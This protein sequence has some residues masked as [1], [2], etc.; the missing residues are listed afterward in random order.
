MRKLTQ[1]AIIVL[2]ILFSFACDPIR[3][4]GQRQGK[5]PVTNVEMQHH[6]D[7]ISFVQ[8]RLVSDTLKCNLHNFVTRGNT[9]NV[10]VS[11]K[12]VE[13]NLDIIIRDNGKDNVNCVDHLDL[14]FD[15]LGVDNKQWTMHIGNN[16]DIDVLLTKDSTMQYIT[17]TIA[18]S[19]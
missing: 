6:N 2:V 9:T 14:K 12:A 11:C 8:L 19:R 5:L 16:W 4:D 17:W 15:I 3:I 18:A 7:T 13:H 10:H 1:G